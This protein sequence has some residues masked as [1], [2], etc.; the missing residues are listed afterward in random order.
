MQFVLIGI[1]LILIMVA[2]VAV[3]QKTINSRVDKLYDK[4][5]EE[6]RRVDLIDSKVGDMKEEQ[7]T[8]NEGYMQLYKSVS[9]M[10]KES[11]APL[12]Q[13]IDKMD[14]FLRAGK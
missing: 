4:V 3:G 1:C 14:D 8:I 9:T 12:S 11:F 2:F 5:N 13:K 7:K 6:A 10:I